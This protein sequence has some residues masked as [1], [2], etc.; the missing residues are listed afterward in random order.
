VLQNGMGTEGDGAWRLGHA[1]QSGC[2]LEPLSF[3]VHQTKQRDRRG[4]GARGQLGERVEYLFRTGIE[5]GQRLQR[6]HALVLVDWILGRLHGLPL[7]SSS[8][9]ADGLNH[10]RTGPRKVDR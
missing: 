1:K 10:F 8:L 7:S 9:Y 5:D 3:M 2:G 4:A 6:R